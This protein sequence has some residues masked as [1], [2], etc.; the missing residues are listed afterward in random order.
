MNDHT[1]D[2]AWLS[3]SVEVDV[4]VAVRPVIADVKL[5]TG[6]LL[7][8]AMTLAYLIAVKPLLSVI[9]SFTVYSFG[10]V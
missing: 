9:V 6:A 1:H 5:A 8:L 7:T 3:A 4:N 10:S 2:I